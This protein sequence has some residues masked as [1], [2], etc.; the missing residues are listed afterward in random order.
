MIVLIVMEDD[1]RFKDRWFR[2]RVEKE[3]QRR[4]VCS[5]FVK[6]FVDN[7]E[8]KFEEVRVLDMESQEMMREWERLEVC[9]K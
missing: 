5:V 3:V 9:V 7:F 6:E 1:I 2:D 4:L 8:G